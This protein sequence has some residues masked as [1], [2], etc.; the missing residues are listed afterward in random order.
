MTRFKRGTVI[1]I[2]YPHSNRVTYKKRPALVVQD[3]SAETGLAKRLVVA[4]TSNLQRTGETRVFVARD[5][6]EGE[7]MGLLTNSV[8]MADNIAAV[9]PREADKVIGRCTVMPEVDSTLRKVLG[10]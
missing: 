3:E 5:S 2:R 6:P 9:I 7:Q 1:L 10:L 8:I 4:I